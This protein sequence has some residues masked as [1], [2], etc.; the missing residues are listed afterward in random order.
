MKVG[1]GWELEKGVP[2]KGNSQW[3]DG[4]ERDFGLTSMNLSVHICLMGLTVV[5]VGP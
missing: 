1:W 2:G 4:E 3:K 5:S